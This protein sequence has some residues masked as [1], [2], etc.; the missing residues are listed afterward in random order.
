MTISID[1]PLPLALRLR[2]LAADL[3]AAVCGEQERQ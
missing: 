2:R 3:M 1:M